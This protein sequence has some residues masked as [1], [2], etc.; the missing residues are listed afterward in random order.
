MNVLIVEDEALAA[1]RLEEL[2]KQ[3]NPD[4]HVLDCIDTVKDTVKFIQNHEHETDLIL[5][6][7]QLADGKSFEIFDQ[8]RFYTPVIFTTAY[9]EFTL[10]AF[11]LNSIDYLLKPIKYEELQAA[12]QKFERLKE[13]QG[14]PIIDKKLISNILRQSAVS[15]KKR[16]L[17]KFGKRMQFKNVEDIAY[18]YAEDKICHIVEKITRKQ[19]IVDHTLEELDDGLLD[20]QTFFRINRQFI[21]NIT[22]IREVKSYFN[23]RL[24]IILNMPCDEKLVVSRKKVRDFKNWMNA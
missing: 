18:L 19:Y 8:V 24:E 5:L 9:D 23:N 11:K 1:E 12:L 7:I 4:I 10:N 17:V 22:A 14:L 6:D 15:Y 21:I 16:F 3:Y 2:V 20:P 13:N